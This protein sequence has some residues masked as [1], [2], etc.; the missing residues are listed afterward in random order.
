M[1]REKKSVRVQSRCNHNKPNCIGSNVT[2]SL[3][4]FG[5][6]LVESVNVEPVDLEG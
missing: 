6:Q 4:I 1:T 3:N 2:V 5:P